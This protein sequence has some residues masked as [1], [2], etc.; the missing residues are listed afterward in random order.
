MLPIIWPLIPTP[1]FVET[2]VY[3][4]GSKKK[5]KQQQQQQPTTKKL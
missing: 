2:K 4:L 3:S 1:R 5:P